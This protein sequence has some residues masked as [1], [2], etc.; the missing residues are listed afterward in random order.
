MSLM[1]SLGMHL[2]NLLSEPEILDSFQFLVKCFMCSSQVSVLLINTPNPKTLLF[3]LAPVENYHK[4]K[5]GCLILLF[6]I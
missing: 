6:L 4:I 3:E 2:T 5:S 1:M